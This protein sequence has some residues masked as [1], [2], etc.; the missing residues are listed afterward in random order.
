VK[1]LRQKMEHVLNAPG[2]IDQA[3]YMQLQAQEQALV[4][5]M[6]TCAAAKVA[7]GGDPEKPPDCRT[8]VAEDEPSASSPPSPAPAPG[9]TLDQLRDQAAKAE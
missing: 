4:K 5:Q 9:P 7:E 1:E 8:D 2:A 6:D 3:L